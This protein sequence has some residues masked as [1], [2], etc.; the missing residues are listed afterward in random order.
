MNADISYVTFS[1]A[2]EAALAIEEMNGKCLNDNPRPLKVVIYLCI[3]HQCPLLLCIVHAVSTSSHC[4]GSHCFAVCRW[5]RA[6]SFSDEQTRWIEVKTVWP[7]IKVRPRRCDWQEEL[8][9]IKMHQKCMSVTVIHVLTFELGE[10][11]WMTHD[12]WYFFKVANTVV[13]YGHVLQIKLAYRYSSV[14]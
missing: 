6:Y 13:H 10:L 3:S 14:K 12:V 7:C 8:W 4:G 9:P 1:K 11:K 5:A 2:S